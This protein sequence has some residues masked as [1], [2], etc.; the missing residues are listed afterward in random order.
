MHEVH[1]FVADVIR[2][3]QEQGVLH[4]D[5]DADAEAW[6]FLSGGFLGMVGRRVGLLDEPEITRIRTARLDWLAS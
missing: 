5:R 2:R 4:R 1:D 6:M 3:G